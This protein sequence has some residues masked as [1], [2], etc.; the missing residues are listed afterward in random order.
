MGLQRVGH[1][2]TTEQQQQTLNC[3]NSL[4]CVLHYAFKDFILSP[5]PLNVL[6]YAFKDFILSPKPSP[7]C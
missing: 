5:K 1:D 6:H 3:T 4:L 7:D 2:L